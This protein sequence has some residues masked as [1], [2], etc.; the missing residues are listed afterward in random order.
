MQTT[1]ACMCD[2][3]AAIALL[4]HSGSPWRRESSL[5]LRIVPLRTLGR[6]QHCHALCCSRL[7]RLP[8]GPLPPPMRATTASLCARNALLAGGKG[9][10]DV[11]N[12][13][14]AVFSIDVAMACDESNVA[15]ESHSGMMCGWGMRWGC[16]QVP[17]CWYCYRATW[18]MDPSLRR[19]PG[20]TSV[21]YAVLCTLFHEARST[22]DF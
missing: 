17:H 7:P 15:A 14:P 3:D 18:D 1:T 19:Q 6:R 22:W 2:L 20:G 16:I 4:L 11:Q 21:A 13:T 12:S 5:L 9:V 10:V 8:R